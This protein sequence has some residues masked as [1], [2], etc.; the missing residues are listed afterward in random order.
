MKKKLKTTNLP[1]KTNL[2]SKKTQNLRG[3]LKYPSLGYDNRGNEWKSGTIVFTWGENCLR[4]DAEP[5]DPEKPDFIATVTLH[6][7]MF[8][9][10]SQR[11]TK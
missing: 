10:L 2:S 7:L 9:Y 1:S 3:Q 6:E 11:L 5:D 4:V 8:S